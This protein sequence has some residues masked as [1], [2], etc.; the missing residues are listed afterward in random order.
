VA[1]E[2][3]SYAEAYKNFT[4]EFNIWQGLDDEVNTM[5]ACKNIGDVL[6]HMEKFKEALEY[7][8]TAVFY[9]RLH[10]YEMEY[11]R[12]YG[13][14]GHIMCVNEQ[15]EN[16]LMC[17]DLQ[18]EV[19]ERILDRNHEDIGITH[20][21]IGAAYCRMKKYEKAIEHFR[22]ALNIYRHSHPSDH[23]NVLKTEENLCNAMRSLN[24]GQ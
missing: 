6:F 14:I 10:N 11:A 8:Q 2:E 15:W 7:L 13:M 5:E 17:Y 19:R 1:A 21:N 24:E 18:L 20:A 9:F 23:P 22:K 4:K 16:C 3:N 12:I